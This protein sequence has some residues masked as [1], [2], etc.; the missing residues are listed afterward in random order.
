[1]Y[2]LEQVQKRIESPPSDK[3]VLQHLRWLYV[4]YLW[5]F[6]DLVFLFT[7]GTNL[8]GVINC[9]CNCALCILPITISIPFNIFKLAKLF[10]VVIH[11]DPVLYRKT[12]DGKW[13]TR[14]VNLYGMSRSFFKIHKKNSDCQGFHKI[15]KLILIVFSMTKSD[16]NRKVH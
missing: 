6:S 5:T 15:W 3:L 8:Y 14:F 4:L 12:C 13:L 10:I 1:M 11:L 2:Q 9:M 16:V 7:L